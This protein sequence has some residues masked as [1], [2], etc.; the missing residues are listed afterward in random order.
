MS[1]WSLDIE[2]AVEDDTE[3]GDTWDANIATVGKFSGTVKGRWGA[4][5]T[6]QGALQTAILN[7]STVAARFYVNASNYYSGTVY[8]T[9]MSPA[10]NVKGLVEV[11]YGVT[12]TGALTYT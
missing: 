2:R 4:D 1:E 11:E 8:V 7:G 3:F 12:G 5:G 6:Q 10:A 9:K